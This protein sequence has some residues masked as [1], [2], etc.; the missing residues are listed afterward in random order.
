LTEIEN[1]DTW[2][3]ILLFSALNKVFR[4]ADKRIQN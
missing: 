1:Q 2:L 4:D 3:I